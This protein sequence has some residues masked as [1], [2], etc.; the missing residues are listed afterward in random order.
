MQFLLGSREKPCSFSTDQYV[1]CAN[2]A[3]FTKT[4]AST[5][6]VSLCWNRDVVEGEENGAKT[7]TYAARPAHEIYELAVLKE[8]HKCHRL[9]YTFSSPKCQ[10]QLV[11]ACRKMSLRASAPLRSRQIGVN[12]NSFVSCSYRLKNYFITD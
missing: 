6:T 3:L 4:K 2:A 10:Q 8:N 7:E 11:I 9:N 5:C 12:V 1:Q